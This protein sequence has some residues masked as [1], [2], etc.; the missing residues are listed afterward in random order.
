MDDKEAELKKRELAIAERELALKERESSAKIRLDQR[1]LMYSSPVLIAIVSTVFGTAIGAGLQGYSD[2]RLERLKFEFSLVQN[3]F[4]NDDI[5]EAA[6]QL[7]FIANSG[8]IRNL[9]AD[10]L[11]SLADTP[12]EIPRGV[13]SEWGQIDGDIPTNPQNRGRLFEGLEDT[14]ENIETD[15]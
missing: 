15:E 11:R 9:D 4:S 10:K 14:T 7:R 13:V 5:G 12:E 1:G 3:A 8:V 6:K 2:I